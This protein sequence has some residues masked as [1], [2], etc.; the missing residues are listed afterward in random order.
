MTR[1]VRLSRRVSRLL[2]PDEH[3]RLEVNLSSVYSHY[4]RSLKGRIPRCLIQSLLSAEDHRFYRHC[5]VDLYALARAAWCTATRGILTG[6][7]TIEQQLVR[8][9]LQRYEKSVSRKLS[10]ILLATGVSAMV[11]KSDVPGLY[12][13]VA[14]FGWRMNGVEEA[15]RRLGFHLQNLSFMQAASLVA[16]LKYP[17]P[18]VCSP[19]RNAQIKGRTHYILR[20]IAK[21]YPEATRPRIGAVTDNATVFDF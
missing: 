14:Y 2:I 11:P 21:R 20:L 5:G 6:G 12:L 13:S 9:L 17:E 10:E 18:R 3:S 16:R 15:C 8:T 19:R 1:A 7:S 4:R